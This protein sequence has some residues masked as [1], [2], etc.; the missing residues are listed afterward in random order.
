MPSLLFNSCLIDALSGEIVFPADLFN[1]MLVTSDYYPN[2]DHERRSDISGEVAAAGYDAG[3]KSVAVTIELDRA[4]RNINLGLGG[5]TWNAHLTARGAVYYKRRGGS[6]SKD[7]LIA[8]IDF[9]DNVI[10]A[11]QRFVLVQ[12]TIQL[13]LPGE[14]P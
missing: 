10:S 8:Y 14:L 2:S 6:P 4:N 12:S 7:E 9:R 3:G 1:A 5:A 13:Q 11:R